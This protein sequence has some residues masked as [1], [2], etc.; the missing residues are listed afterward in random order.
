MDRKKE[1][2]EIFHNPSACTL[3]DIGKLLYE[4]YCRITDIEYFTY[5]ASLINIGNIGFIDI[6][7]VGIEPVKLVKEVSQDR[8]IRIYNLSFDNPDILYINPIAAP[9]GIPINAGEHEGI[10]VREGRTIFGSFAN[11]TNKVAVAYMTV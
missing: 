5:R 4:L 8:V 9:Y 10:L 1:F 6:I 7:D 2:E 11:T 3:N